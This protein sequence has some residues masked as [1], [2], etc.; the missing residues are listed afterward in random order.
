VSWEEVLSYAL[1]LSFALLKADAGLHELVRRRDAMGS[2]LA[3]EEAFVH[4][5]FGDTSGTVSTT[6]AV[7]G[8]HLG[9]YKGLAAHGPSTSG[10]FAAR[11]GLSERYA[12]EWLGW[13]VSAGYLQYDPASRRFKLPPEPAPAL[14]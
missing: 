13:M 6:L 1:G 5:V 9:L 10:A 7:F 2:E 11:R 4:K 14:A 8:D 3:L 12:Q